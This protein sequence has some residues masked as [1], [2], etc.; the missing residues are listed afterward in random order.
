M[1]FYLNMLLNGIWI[2]ATFNAP[3]NFHLKVKLSSCL[4]KHQA[5]KT[6]GSVQHQASIVSG[7]VY[8][9]TP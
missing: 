4:V 3:Y 8:D 7:Q 2:R 1:K 9:R 6:Y 5:I